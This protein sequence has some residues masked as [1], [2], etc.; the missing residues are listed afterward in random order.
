MGGCY[1]KDTNPPICFQ[2]KIK[3][4]GRGHWAVYYT[5][6]QSFII[7]FSYLLA[8]QLR[9]LS[10]NFGNLSV[11]TFQPLIVLY[12]RVNRVYHLWDVQQFIVHCLIP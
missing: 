8:Q 12:R 7:A 6:P 1:I 2:T 9:G 5:S 10:L 3:G 11:K 4:E